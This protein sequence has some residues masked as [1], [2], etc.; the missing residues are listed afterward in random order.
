[1]SVRDFRAFVEVF[2]TAQIQWEAMSVDVHMDTKLMQLLA[3]ISMN[4]PIKES[5]RRTL[6]AEIRPGIIPV[7]AMLVSR[8]TSAQMSTNVPLSVVVM[9][10]LLA[11][12]VME[13]TNVIVET[14]TAATGKIVIKVGMVTLVIH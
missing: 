13:A 6:Y 1:M 3:L 10:T 8:A 14:V 2:C 4:V 11:R 5:V 12:I 9:R 7:I